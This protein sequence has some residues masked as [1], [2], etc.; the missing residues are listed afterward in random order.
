MPCECNLYSIHIDLSKKVSLEGTQDVTFTCA[1]IIWDVPVP[2]LLLM[3]IF[4]LISKDINSISM[5]GWG[6]D[7]NLWPFTPGMD[8]L[9]LTHIQ[10][11]T[12]QPGADISLLPHL[13][14]MTFH[15]WCGHPITDPLKIH[16]I[17]LQR[18][19]SHNW[20]TLNPWSFTPKTDSLS[21]ILLK[22]MT[23]YSWDRHYITDPQKTHDPSLLGWR[24]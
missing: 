1:I 4:S 21:L 23:V 5:L 10:P 2:L 19:T 15:S 17:S 13:N 11:M 18:W 22:L 6:H 14:L 8:T 7:S 12:F 20:P 16:D 24:A 9:S 3:L